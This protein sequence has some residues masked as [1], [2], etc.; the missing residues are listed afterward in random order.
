[1]AEQ[2]P[3]CGPV[4]CVHYV[5]STVD[6]PDLTDNSGNGV[7]DY[8]DRALA[9]L[10]RV[11]R[12]YVQAGYKRPRGDGARGGSTNKVDVYLGDIDAGGLYG[13][14]TTDEQRQGAP[15]D[16]WAYCVLDDDYA[17]IPTNT[18]IENLQVTAA[19]EYF[20]AVQYAYDYLEDSWFLEAT[21]A[22]VED[23]MY[24]AVDD[25]RQYLRRSP[26]TIPNRPMDQFRTDD[27]WHYGV[28]IFFRYLTERY[29]ASK[30]GL[31]TLVR[32]MLRRADGTGA[33][34][35]D[36]YSWQA[37]NAVLRGRGSS[38]AAEFASFAAANRRPRATYSE[39]TA[40]SYPAA[41]LAGSVQLTASRPNTAGQV[42]LDHLSSATVRLV[43]RGLVGRGLEAAAAARP[44]T[45]GPRVARGHHGHRQERPGPPGAGLA[46]RPG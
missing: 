14:C 11:H 45:V 37:V 23:E 28:W 19:H 2:P 42:V 1:M 34:R 4:V 46:Q 29:P 10:N 25:N 39:G 20:H 17:N 26:L 21:A 32:D 6:A 33:P 38:A 18:A 7:P 27:G 43:P 36:F 15:Y 16:R 44:R 35:N 31:P 13:Y 40:L 9:I 22:W 24:D 12:T 30:A 5:A 3:V 8:V 41:P